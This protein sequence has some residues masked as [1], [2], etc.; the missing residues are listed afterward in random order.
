MA[1]VIMKKHKIMA[2]NMKLFYRISLLIALIYLS[3]GMLSWYQ[4]SPVSADPDIEN[5]WSGSNSVS[6]PGQLTLTSS[7]S[8]DGSGTGTWADANGLWS[9]SPYESWTFFIGD[10]AVGAGTINSVTLYL[11]HYQSGWADDNFLVQIYDGSIWHDVQSYTSGSGPPTSDTTNNWDIS[12]TIDTWT[13]IDAAQ[14]RIIGNGKDKGE[15]AVDWFIDT[16]EIRIDYTPA[17][18]PDISNNPGS[19]GFGNVAEGSTT[20][21]GLTYFTL[22]NN[23]GFAID[24][25]ISGTDMTGGVGWT[26]SDTAT[27]GSDTYGLR[28]GLE[29]GSYDIIVK[30][31]GPYNFLITG[32]PGSGTTQRW[33]LQLMAPTSFSDGAVKSGTITL[34]AAQS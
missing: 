22:T 3:S 11:K 15:D 28:A 1:P 34:T 5:L 13:K 17:S 31:T 33:G 7:S 24:V 30:K 16:V 20:S 21:T 10:S 25:T 14:V 6:D 9:A 32:M 2:N 29:G 19:Y 26:L 8:A 12:A 23:S 27:P 4:V 18:V